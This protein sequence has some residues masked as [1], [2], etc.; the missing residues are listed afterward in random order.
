MTN[1]YLIRHA[2]SVGNIEKRLTGRVDY[3]LTD[4]GRNQVKKLTDRLKDVH[5]DVAYSSPMSRAIDTIKPLTELNNLDAI[6]EEKL[7][8]MY[9]GIYD[10]FKWKEVNEID[11][12][13]SN[14]R[15]ETNEISGISNQESTQQVKKRMYKVISNIAD[16]NIGK[17]I[18]IASHGV[19]IEAFLRQ[20]TG[21]PFA[22]K[23]QEYSPQ[24]TSINIVQ[25]NEE[26]NKFEIKL[27]NDLEHLNNVELAR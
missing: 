10:G 22:I 26:N 11:A 27:L 23:K 20:I 24:N 17:T 13:I 3:M 9:F 14:R 16:N 1:I 7:S 15:K 6:K 5:F 21:E 18:L 19:A 25:Y 12:S 2:Q 4:E 8:E